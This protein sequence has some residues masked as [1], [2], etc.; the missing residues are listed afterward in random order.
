MPEPW[1]HPLIAACQL[2]VRSLIEEAEKADDLDLWEEI[3]GKLTDVMLT[4]RRSLQPPEPRR[5]LTLSP[6]QI[7][8]MEFDHAMAKAWGTDEEVQ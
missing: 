2:S 8:S 1:Q 4:Y 6:A 5:G 7:D 3:D